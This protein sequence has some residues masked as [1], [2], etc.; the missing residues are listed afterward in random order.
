MV[1][2]I[3]SKERCCSIYLN[4]TL[5]QTG[6]PGCPRTS[7]APPDCHCFLWC[8]SRFHHSSCK[9]PFGICCVWGPV[10][11][12]GAWCWTAKPKWFQGAFSLG[13]AADTYQQTLM[14]TLVMTQNCFPTLVP[15]IVLPSSSP[16]WWISLVKFCLAYENNPN[17]TK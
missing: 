17:C 7:F 5:R 9:N 4:E 13:R 10:L 6:N 15:S 3:A 12:L 14:W 8:V 16:R 11:V 1:L 2:W